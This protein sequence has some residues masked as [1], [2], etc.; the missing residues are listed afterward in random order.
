[1]RLLVEP[2]PIVISVSFW[3]IFRP[4]PHARIK[5]EVSES[6][7]FHCVSRRPEVL[8]FKVQQTSQC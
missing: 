1:M 6:E 7:E 2:G 3:Y 8:L 4:Q 5:S